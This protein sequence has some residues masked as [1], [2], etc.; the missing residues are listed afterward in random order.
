MVNIY[1]GT[2][3][4]IKKLIEIEAISVSKAMLKF[5][6]VDCK[7]NSKNQTIFDILETKDDTFGIFL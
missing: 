3:N 7:P 4:R 1:V 2:P 5:I 6:I